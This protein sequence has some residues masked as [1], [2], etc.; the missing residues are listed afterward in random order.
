M[1]NGR[2]VTLVISGKKR[3]MCTYHYFA[4]QELLYIVYERCKDYK[5]L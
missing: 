1:N 3:A 4:L 2:F 5:L